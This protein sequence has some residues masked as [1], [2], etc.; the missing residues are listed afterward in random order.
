MATRPSWPPAPGAAA[1]SISGVAISVVVPV[2]DE[3]DNV[4]PL[5][6][7]LVSAL[8]ALGRPYEIVIV[9]DGSEDATHAR[10]LRL[11]AVDS[12]PEARPAPAQLRPDGG[13]GGR[14]STTR[15]GDVI[16]PMDGDLQNDPADIGR[17]L[18]KLD[19]GYDV[20]SGWRRD[21][22]DSFVRRAPLAHG[23]LADRRG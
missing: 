6:H 7:A 22:K 2:H 21:R 17:L 15:R 5:Y 18:A 3:E 11:A 1:D 10:L 23:E 16:V 20:V 19:E 12:R 14:V 9:D 4:E 13:D 8:T